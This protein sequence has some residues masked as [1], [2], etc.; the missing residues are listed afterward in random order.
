MTNRRKPARSVKRLT[1]VL[2]NVDGP[3]YGCEGAPPGTRRTYPSSVEGLSFVARAAPS[4]KGLYIQLIIDVAY[5]Q[6]FDKRTGA[7]KENRY[8]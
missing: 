2:G 4:L 8:K 1:L 6:A 3:S 5:S 7:R